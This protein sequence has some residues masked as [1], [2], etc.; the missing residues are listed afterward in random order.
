MDHWR[1]SFVMQ[2]TLITLA[3]SVFNGRRPT[4]THTTTHT[5]TNGAKIE[6]ANYIYQAELAN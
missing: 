4:T 1:S 2:I 5:Q 3:S 6:N